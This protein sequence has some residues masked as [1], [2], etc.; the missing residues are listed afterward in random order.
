[1]ALETKTIGELKNYSFVIPDYQRGYRW[2]SNEIKAL[3]NDLM[4]A[5]DNKCSHYCVQPLIVKKSDSNKYEV[6]DGQQRLTTIFIFMKIAC[7]E[8]K[9]ATPPFSLEY[10][11]RE[12]SEEFL[13]SLSDSTD[14]DA[15]GKEN[16][17]YYF[18]SEA[19]KTINTW[20]DATPDKSIAITDINSYMRKSVFFLWYELPDGSNPIEEFTN[21]NLGKIPLTNSE[22]IK[23]LFLNKDLFRDNELAQQ[24]VNPEVIAYKRANDIAS[25]WDRIE[26]ELSDDS[27]WGFISEDEKTENR[28]D[29]LF[30]YMA[31][32]KAEQF[33][34]SISADEK[35]YSFVVFSNLLKLKNNMKERADEVGKLWDEFVQ[36]FAEVKSWYHDFDL[37]HIIGYLI[38]SGVK[39]KDIFALTKNKT[40]TKRFSDLTEKCRMGD[41]LRKIVYSSDKRKLRNI[42][43]LFNIA[44]LVYEDKKEYRFPFYLIKKKDPS[45]KLNWDIEHIHA[46]AN[47]SNEE[48]EADDS[49]ANLTLLSAEIN[50]D[51]KYKASDFDVK[52]RILLEYDSKGRFIPICTKNVFNKVYSDLTNNDYKDW[53]EKDKESYISRME[54]VFAQFFSGKKNVDQKDSTKQDDKNQEVKK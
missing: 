30:D 10:N 38:Y 44:T 27:F 15:K 42:L 29:L 18:I 16:I 14:L 35:Y 5:I 4:E 9:S 47:N 6:V 41:D 52:R 22:L 1:M 13:N 31:H 54:T 34:L 49:L 26:H 36:L 40:R 45:K 51:P 48:A 28:M 3:L 7:Q 8:I 39:L 25:E 53:Y 33:N 32:E 21:I 46:T 17:D 43:V 37:Y 50:R 24:G 2:T 12:K 19:Y 11:T 23:A 20:L